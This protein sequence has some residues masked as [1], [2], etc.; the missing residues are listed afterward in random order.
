MYKTLGGGGGR[1]TPGPPKG[2]GKKR[3]RVFKKITGVIS[4]FLGP[5]CFFFPPLFWGPGV[6]PPPP[7]PQRFVHFLNF[8][9]RKN[10]YHQLKEG[11]FIA[12]CGVASWLMRSTPDRA[13]LVRA[14]AG[15]IALCSWARHFT[16][17]VPLSTH[18]GV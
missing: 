16:L 10:N 11:L 12:T 8:S 13:D 9:S 14:P 3:L 6:S 5:F 1:E 18:A 4:I 17:I 15:N 7:P 2:G